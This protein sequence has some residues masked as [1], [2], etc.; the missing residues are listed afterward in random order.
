MTVDIDAI[1]LEEIKRQKHKTVL[2][3]PNDS[4]SCCDWLMVVLSFLL[5]VLTFPLTIWRCFKIIHQNE[6]AVLY[7]MG[8]IW[9]GSKGPGLVFM[10]PFTDT[11]IKV[12]TKLL[13]LSIPS[14]EVLTSDFVTVKVRAVVC[15]RIKDAVKAMANVTDVHTATQLFSQSTLRNIL[16]TKTV[17]EILVN[18]KEIT[19]SMKAILDYA[20]EDWG[21]EVQWVEIN[22]LNF[23]D[24]QLQKIVAAKVMAAEG[25]VNAARMLKQASLMMGDS[26]SAFKLRYLQTMETLAA[27]KSIKIQ[28]PFMGGTLVGFDGTAGPAR[29]Y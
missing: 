23:K 29:I 3:T 11:L 9:R 24:Q 19:D 10:L 25:E 17:S 2:E 21:I 13:T 7:R 14:Q 28:M 16:G 18:N 27:D 15:Y 4:M 26:E 8:H 12:S 1:E 20:T 22:T 5:V 6:R